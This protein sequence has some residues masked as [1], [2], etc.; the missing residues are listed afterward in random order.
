MGFGVSNSEKKPVATV[1]V[2]SVTIPIYAAPVTVTKPVDATDAKTMAS[3]ETRTYQSF[4]LSHYEG[5]RRILQRRNTLERAKSLAKEIASRLNRDGSRAAFLTEK[6]RRV[7]I[8]SQLAVKPLG[9]EV[10]EVCR[11]YVELQKRLKTGT[12]EQAV[13]FCNAHGQR[14]R[15]G[16]TVEDIY[17]LNIW[18]IWKNAAWAIITYGTRNAMWV[19]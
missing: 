6:D 15:H 2:G 8:L 9:M 3:T 16:A 1:T 10:D 18:R 7:L 19:I 5:A 13:D 17:T 12:V 14:I 4:Q 11:K